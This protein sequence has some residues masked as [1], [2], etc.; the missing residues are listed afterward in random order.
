MYEAH[1]RARVERLRGFAPPPDPELQRELRAFVFER[2]PETLEAPRE[3]LR[4]DVQ[5]RDTLFVFAPSRMRFRLAAGEHRVA[6]LYGLTLDPQGRASSARALFRA[7]LVEEGRT[8]GLWESWL[9]AEA[10]PEGAPA[11]PLALDFRVEGPADLVLATE[12]ARDDSLR[13]AWCWWSDVRIDRI[14]PESP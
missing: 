12:L 6:G 9:E 1:V 3:T 10:L 14:D 13:N 11:Q 4:A 2:L 8:R 5:G 7:A